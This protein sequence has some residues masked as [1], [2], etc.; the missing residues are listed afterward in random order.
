MLCSKGQVRQAG[1]VAIRAQ[2][3]RSWRHRYAACDYSHSTSVL[4]LSELS[5]LTGQGSR[6]HMPSALQAGC[7]RG[8]AT[9]EIKVTHN[10]LCH[11]DIHVS[12]GEWGPVNYPMV[13]G[14]EVHFPYL[15]VCVAVCFARRTY[16]IVS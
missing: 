15:A 13:P 2:A 16:K 8:T 7:L 9:A 10:G 5:V 14:H 3:S 12:R 1:T 4:G 11:S 6:H